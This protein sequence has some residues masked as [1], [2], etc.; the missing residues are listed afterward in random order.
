MAKVFRSSSLAA[1]VSTLFGMNSIGGVKGHGYISRPAARNVRAGEYDADSGNGAGVCG[2][3]AAWQRNYIDYYDG[4]K[5]TYTAGQVV[6]F[7][8]RI[9]VPHYGH[10]ELGICDRRINSSMQDPRACLRMGALEK[11][12]WLSGLCA[13]RLARALPAHRPGVP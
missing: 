9:T 4:V 7:E 6:D 12:P 5:A 2:D 8:M 1:C 3:R 10:F 13:E 11:S